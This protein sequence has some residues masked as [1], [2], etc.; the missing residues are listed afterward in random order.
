ML[1]HLGHVAFHQ[2]HWHE[3]EARFVE[4][5]ALHRERGNTGGDAGCLIGLA[6]LAQG[7]GQPE[8]AARV[9]GAAKRLL[10]SSGSLS[11]MR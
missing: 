3:A 7:H 2:H 10:E 5:L 11:R 8:R 4:S 1:T 9:L 6:K